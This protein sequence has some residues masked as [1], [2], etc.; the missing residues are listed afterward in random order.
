MMCGGKKSSKVHT[1]FDQPKAA[2]SS[3]KRLSFFKYHVQDRESIGV[4]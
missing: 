4:I 1:Y 2:G 3:F